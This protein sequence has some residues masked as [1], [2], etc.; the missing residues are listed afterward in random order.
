MAIVGGADTSC[1]ARVHLYAVM[2][3]PL[4]ILPLCA[5]FTNS[6]VKKDILLCHHKVVFACS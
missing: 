1:A 4:S 6:Q 3:T 2:D 5:V